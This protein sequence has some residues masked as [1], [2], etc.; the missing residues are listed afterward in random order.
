M[1]QW[2][3]GFEWICPILN[4]KVIASSHLLQWP[5]CILRH[6]YT[7][8]TGCYWQQM[9]TF[10]LGLQGALGDL[11]QYQDLKAK[12]LLWSQLLP[13]HFPWNENQQA[14]LLAFCLLLFPERKKKK[15][16]AS[17]S[18]FWNSLGH[19]S[20]PAS[21]STCPRGFSFSKSCQFSLLL[22]T[23]TASHPCF[24][25]LQDWPVFQTRVEGMGCGLSS[26]HRGQV[27]KQNAGRAAFI[28]HPLFHFL[29]SD[30]PG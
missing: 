7:P 9:W 19:I 3:C 1:S 27:A 13:H 12:I 24:L 29:P 21:F 17:L 10:F 28:L 5:L 2:S 18:W 11:E 4:L 14:T 22:N 8:L 20:A 26:G 30:P 16:K 15:K 25:D 23:V 6:T